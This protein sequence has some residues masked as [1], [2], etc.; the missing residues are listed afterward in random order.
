M[1]QRPRSGQPI[2]D[3]EGSGTWIETDEQIQQALAA[4]ARH[5]G[6]PPKASPAAVG[7]PRPGAAGQQPVASANRAARRASPFRPTA[8][9]PIAVLTVFDD[10]KTS[11][12]VIR[13]REP[14]FVIGR[15]EGDLRIGLDSHI[16]ARHLDIT[17]HCIGGFHR[18][19]ITDLQSTHGLFVR[20]SRTALADKT[21]FLVGGGRYR[22]DE[23]QI[24]GGSTTDLGMDGH[25]AS[26]THGWSDGTARVRAPAVTELLGA[27]IGNRIIL[28]KPRYWIGSDPACEICRPEDPFCEPQHVRLYRKPKG[29]WHAEHNKTY[30]GL[31]V[32]MTQLTVES[33]AQFQIGEQRFQLKVP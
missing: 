31:W 2:A 1:T 13:L 6:R 23:L 29:T 9:P 22:F 7:S 18:W 14:H 30:N 12:E 8:R 5:R 16:S 10:G 26:A 15:T 3:A 19:V 32:R 33:L 24:D 11:G 28:I 25:A 17:Y 21:E 4:A 20:V 27:R